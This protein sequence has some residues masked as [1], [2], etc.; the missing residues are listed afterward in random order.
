MWPW[1]RDLPT[2]LWMGNG[3]IMEEDGM[4][5]LEPSEPGGAMPGIQIFESIGTAVDDSQH[6]GSEV[7]AG[8]LTKFRGLDRQSC[9]PNICWAT[10]KSCWRIQWWEG[11][12]RKHVLFPIKQFLEQAFSE[13]EAVAASLR[14]A[15]AHREELVHKGILK[16]AKALKPE[17]G[18]RSTVKGVTY[19]KTHEKW[20]VQLAHPTTKKK[21]HGGRFATQEEAESKAR[22]LAKELGIKEVDHKIVPVKKL[23]ELKH[24]EPL[25]SQAGVQWSLGEQCWR[26]HCTVAGKRRNM[27]FRPKDFS[28]KGLDE[29]WKQAVAWRKQQEKEKDQAKKR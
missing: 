12:K 24:F 4:R 22:E 10:H 18:K 21:V 19:H 20:Q 27:R 11:G 3:W 29:A 14:E 16:P 13:D 6:D 26:A 25:S 28:E 8:R 23:S 2:R 1:M 5:K 15:K 7:Q 17:E 9:V